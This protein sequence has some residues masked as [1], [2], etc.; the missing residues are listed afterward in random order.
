M[1]L[2]AIEHIYSGHPGASQKQK[3]GADRQLCHNSFGG[4]LLDEN[5][6]VFLLAAGKL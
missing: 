4:V 5:D 2:A 3:I 6:P 1:A